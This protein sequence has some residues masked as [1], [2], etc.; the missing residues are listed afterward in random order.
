MRVHSVKHGRHRTCRVSVSALF[1]MTSFF[2]CS[3]SLHKIKGGGKEKR[4]AFNNYYRSDVAVF[5]AR[6]LR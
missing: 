2:S 4:F 6:Y 3:V 5:C 1:V